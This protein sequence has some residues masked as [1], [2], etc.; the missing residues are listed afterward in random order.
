[1]SGQN[2]KPRIVELAERITEAVGRLQG[3]FVEKGLQMPS[4]DEDASSEMPLEAFDVRDAVLDASTEIYDIFLDPLTLM[5]KRGSYNNMVSLQAISRFKIAPMVPAQGQTTFAEI[6]KQTGVQEQ[7]IQ[8]LLRHAITMRVFCEPQPGQVA[9]TQASKA[10]ADPSVAKWL[11]SGAEDFWPA[12]VRIV[13]AIEKWGDSQEPNHTGFALANNTDGT[14]YDVVSSDPARAAR[15]AGCMNAHTSTSAH[16]LSYILDYYDWAALGQA[17]VVDLGGARG[18]VSIALASRFPNLTL[19]P[20]R[21]LVALSFNL[22]LRF[23]DRSFI[24]LLPRYVFLPCDTLVVQ[25][26]EKVVEGAA[27]ELPE[28]LQGRV[29]FVAHDLFSRQEV[30]ADVYYLRWI[31]HNWSN[32]YCAIILQNLI[33]ALKPG[34]RILIHESCMPEP[35]ETALWR[36]QDLRMMD[37]NMGAGFNAQERTV[38]DWKGILHN[39]DAR[40]ILRDVIQP[41]G[42]AL[43][44]VDVRWTGE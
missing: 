38:S 16:S 6:S 18:H 9:H 26:M 39:A 35:G 36:E 41:K 31:L 34:T 24:D 2:D 33:P 5:L 11:S 19:C 22:S 44:L 3:I 40:F 30:E 25:D 17:R 20:L 15:F 23:G 32:K 13:D 43:A 27:A 42:S 29:Q 1:M 8:R 10:L 7:T 21:V 28:T 4:F 12:A 37:L 14:V